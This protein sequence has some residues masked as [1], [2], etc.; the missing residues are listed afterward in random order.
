MAGICYNCKHT[1]YECC[2]GDGYC[3]CVDCKYYGNKIIS[4]NEG[5]KITNCNNYEY[6]YGEK[7]ENTDVEILPFD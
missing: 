7:G 3:N 2:Y 4:D 1:Y 6:N 5:C